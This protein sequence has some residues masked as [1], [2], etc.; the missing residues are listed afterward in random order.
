MTSSIG[1]STRWAD[2]LRHNERPTPA[3]LREHLLEVHRQQTGFTETCA[4]NSRD[5]RGRNSYEW[6]L[7][8]LDADCHGT[9]LDLA[10]GSGPLTE[11]CHR[12]L[13][14]GVQV[15]G[16]DMSD[17]ELA[18]ARR[19]V[20]AEAATFHRAMAQDMAFLD[21]GSADAVL[22]HWALTLMDPVEPVIMEIERVL[23]TGGVFAAIVDGDM[24]STPCYE[25]QHRIIFDW[26]R[27][28]FP[29]YGSIDL[30]DPRVRTPDAL[31]ELVNEFFREDDI[32]IEPSVVRL[33]GDPRTLAMQAAGFFYASFVLSP[34]YHARMLDDL[35]RDFATRTADPAGTA[36]AFHM[37]LNRLVVRRRRS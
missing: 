19:R 5:A 14:Q 3:D 27:R 32:V 7:E 29:R 17:E 20:P 1:L 22:C 21:T 4:T 30:G 36:S 33:V 24:R 26:V 16:V 10:C 34:E 31:C 11:L 37:P 25:A 28:E 23:R 35:E 13:P 12:R 8:A 18:L 9:V 2:C 15:I 6:L